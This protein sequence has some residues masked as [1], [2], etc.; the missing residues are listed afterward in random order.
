MYIIGNLLNKILHKCKKWARA[1]VGFVFLPV[2]CP[3]SSL[4]CIDREGRALVSSA[5]PG[6]ILSCIYLK[7]FIN[8][9]F[10][11]K[12]RSSV[13]IEFNDNT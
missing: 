4:F 12:L 5:S 10:F 9:A 13:E 8:S 7:L 1:R 11:E 2:N 3:W 6:K